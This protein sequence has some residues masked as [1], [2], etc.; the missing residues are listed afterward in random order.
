LSATCG[1]GVSAAAPV[2]VLVAL[3]LVALPLVALPLV[4]LL[5]VALVAA[6]PVVLLVPVLIVSPSVARAVTP[7]AAAR[8]VRG[9]LPPA[10]RLRGVRRRRLAMI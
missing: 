9:L 1:P 4:A 10:G 6:L 3:P 7:G 5:L 2:P 8:D